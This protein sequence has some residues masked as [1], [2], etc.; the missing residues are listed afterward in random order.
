MLLVSCTLFMTCIISTYIA[1]SCKDLV[2]LWEGFLPLPQW[3]SGLQ[4]NIGHW[5][6]SQKLIKIPYMLILS[7]LT[8]NIV[9]TVNFSLL[10]VFFMDTACAKIGV[11]K[12]DKINLF[13]VCFCVP[14]NI[15]VTTIS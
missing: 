14:V 11:K 8:K 9:C 2:G 13:Y 6:D 7:M 1:I 5:L 15:G 3:L 12:S 4:I 10:S